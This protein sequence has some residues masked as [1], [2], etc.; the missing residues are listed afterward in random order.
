MVLKTTWMITCY[1]ERDG[2]L[3]LRFSAGKIWL[4]VCQMWWCPIGGFT[5][6]EE[7]RISTQMYPY[8][9]W[10]LNHKDDIIQGI[11]GRWWSHHQTF[12]SEVLFIK[13]RQSWTQWRSHR[14]SQCR[15]WFYFITSI[16]LAELTVNGK[17]QTLPKENELLKWVLS[18]KRFVK[19]SCT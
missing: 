4:S 8:S 5:A 6:A 9:F 7:I 1:I 16:T 15:I 2:R 13:S 11:T 3:G 12:D 18:I 17:V 14:G 19:R 10:V